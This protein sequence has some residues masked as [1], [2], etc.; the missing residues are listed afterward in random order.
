MTDIIDLYFA[1]STSLIG[2]FITL[3][4]YNVIKLKGKK[5][6]DEERMIIWRK[7]FGKLFRILGVVM[8][9]IGISLL[10]L[11]F[12]DK[13]NDKWTE[14]HKEDMKSLVINNSPFIQS[15][16]PELRDLVVTCFVET[17]TKKYTLKE[18]LGEVKEGQWPEEYQLTVMVP[19]MRECFE[20][21]GL[22][23]GK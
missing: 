23:E 14:S 20:K 10:I 17:Y 19:I 15:L 8:I 4:G 13:R 7:K 21:Y 18:S 22:I 6:E 1:I 2:L 16:N 3:I 5:P 11:S 12:S 9:F